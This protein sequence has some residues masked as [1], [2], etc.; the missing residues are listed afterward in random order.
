[1]VA[2]AVLGAAVFALSLLLPRYA[3]PL[4]WIGLFLLLDPVNR[5]LGGTACRRRS[6]GVAGTPSSFLGPL[7]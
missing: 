6:N 4:V 1:L 2:I 3:F 7:V 5:L